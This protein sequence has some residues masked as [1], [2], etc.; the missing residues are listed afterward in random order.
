MNIWQI[1]KKSLTEACVIF[2]VIFAFIA[3]FV[4][5]IDKSEGLYSLGQT[6][7]FFIFALIFAIANVIMRIK[8]L[9]FALRL[10]LHFLITAL[11]F[12]FCFMLYMGMKGT[13]LLIGLFL[14]AVVYFIC[15]L[16]IGLLVSR[17]RKIKN[18]HSDY[19]KKFKSG[20]KR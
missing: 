9:S 7:L 3:I 5:S 11:G 17:F 1:I 10:F 18:A 14:Y 6:F 12:Y 4:L 2:C 19:E 16:V 8:K 15:A 13:Q 20:K